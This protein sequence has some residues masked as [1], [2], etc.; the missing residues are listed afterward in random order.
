MQFAGGKIKLHHVCLDEWSSC[1]PF[2]PCKKIRPAKITILGAKKFVTL[3][4]H[5]VELQV[6]VKQQELM[7]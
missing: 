1:H 7:S 3:L 5:L 2:S 4:S 6:D